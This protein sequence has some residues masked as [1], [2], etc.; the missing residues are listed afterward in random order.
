MPAQAAGRSNP[1]KFFILGRSVVASG[2]LL[3]PYLFF[4]AFGIQVAGT[5]AVPMGRMFGVRNAL[6]ALGLARLDG[7]AA[8]RTF[9]KLNVLIDAV[10]AVALASAGRRGEISKLSSALGTG[11]ALSAVALGVVSLAALPPQQV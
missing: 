8:P 9:L 2:S 1:L 6:L 3:A 10:D 7:F 5:A 11:V 4:R